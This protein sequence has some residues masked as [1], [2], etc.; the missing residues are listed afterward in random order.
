[1]SP[2]AIPMRTQA[3]RFLVLGLF[4]SLGCAADM[5]PELDADPADVAGGK[6]DQINGNDDPSGLLDQAERRLASLVTMADVGQSFGVPADEIPYPDTYWPM[7]DNGIA[8]DWLETSG[9]PCRTP[10]ECDDPQDSPLEKLVGLIDPT[11]VQDAIDWEVKHHGKD[12]PNVASWFGHCPGWV[13]TAMLYPPVQKPLWVQREGLAW[14]KCEAGDPECTKFEIG[15][16]NAIGAEAHEGARSR[17][18][19]AR[20]DTEPSEIE[21]DEFGRIVRN[22]T[23]CKGLNAGAMLIVM[24]NRLKM[25]GK[26][27]AIDAQ[28]ESNTEQIWNQPAFRY[29]VNRFEE[30][31]ETE[32]A[33][34]VASGGESRTGEQD[35]YIWN[36]DAAGFA[37]VD[38]TLHWVSETS[39]PNLV[40]V[41]GATTARK[42]RMVA[43]IELD[44]DTTDPE[45]EIIGGEYLDDPSAG[46]NRLRVAPFVWLALDSGLDSRHNP[47][48]KAAEVEKLLE[49]A[50]QDDVV[51]GG[52]EGDECAHPVCSEGEA[53][54]AA[55]DPCVAKVCA[56]DSFC[57]ENRWDDV[58]VDEVA[59]I[60]EQTCE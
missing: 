58:C 34:L 35:E 13:A 45:A 27:F 18:I 30:L 51:G 37:F 6:A 43:V 54:E 2:Q 39:G 56:A 15:D 60:C 50:L 14:T 41:S 17:F 49:L 23:G 4:A 8:V 25:E 36:V 53:L 48:V 22:G 5:A 16:L 10:N 59:T 21:R 31:S 1:M 11:H 7:I 28:N 24:G 12:V 26:P 52:E 38:V 20:C 55:C 19:G 57:C 3:S 32:A 33:N 46:A 29:S 9:E 44:G 47:F 42:T 40:P